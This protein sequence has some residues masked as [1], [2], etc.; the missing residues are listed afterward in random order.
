M[1]LELVLKVG[2]VWSWAKCRF[3]CWSWPEVA[4]E[5]GLKLVRV[6]PGV[7][8]GD[9]AGVGLKLVPKMGQVWVMELMLELVLKLVLELGQMW[10]LR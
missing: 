10:V 8:A 4:D 2:Q 7:D 9:G 6:D 3:W 5:V 1:V